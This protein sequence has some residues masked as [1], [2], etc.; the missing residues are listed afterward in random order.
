MDR[1]DELHV[2]KP[3]AED[4]DSLPSAEDTDSGAVPEDTDDSRS[5][6]ENGSL[7]QNISDNQSKSQNEDYRDR[8]SE[9]SSRRRRKQQKPQRCD[10][11]QPSGSNYKPEVVE[12]ND[13]IGPTSIDTN[14]FEGSQPET[15]INMQEGEDGIGLPSEMDTD[16][17]TGSKSETEINMQPTS[18]KCFNW[19]PQIVKT[20]F[21]SKLLHRSFYKKGTSSTKS[22]IRSHC[23]QCAE[24]GKRYYT[25]KFLMKHISIKHTIKVHQCSFCGKQYKL[26]DS[27]K[28]HIKRDHS[29]ETHHCI[30]CDKYF[31]S[32][33]TLKQH[34]RIHTGEKP[35]SC[36]HCRMRFRYRHQFRNHMQAHSGVFMNCQMCGKL[37]N[38]LDSYKKHIKMC[39]QKEG[40]RETNISNGKVCRED[41]VTKTEVSDLFP[42]PSNSAGEKESTSNTALNKLDHLHFSGH[43]CKRCDV[44]FTDRQAL[45]KHMQVKHRKVILV[46][47]ICNMQYHLR[48]SL[49]KHVKS[50]HKLKLKDN[51]NTKAELE[52]RKKLPLCDVEIADVELDDDDKEPNSAPAESQSDCNLDGAS[53]QPLEVLSAKQYNQMAKMYPQIAKMTKCPFCDNFYR[54]IETLRQHIKNDHYLNDM[55]NPESSLENKDTTCR[56]SESSTVPVGDMKQNPSCKRE[57]G[58]GDM[59]DKKSGFSSLDDEKT[60]YQQDNRENKTL[61]ED[62]TTQPMDIFPMMTS[63]DDGSKN[64]LDEMDHSN[65]QSQISPQKAQGECFSDGAPFKQ[66]SNEDNCDLKGKGRDSKDMLSGDTKVQ[67][68]SCDTCG[69][70]LNNPQDLDIHVQMHP[71][72]PLCQKRYGLKDSLRK[73]IKRSHPEY[74][75]KM[76]KKKSHLEKAQLL[77]TNDSPVIPGQLRDENMDEKVNNEPEVFKCETC[78]LCFTSQDELDSHVA[79]HPTCPCCS[80]RYT[81]KDSLRKHIKRTHPALHWEIAEERRNSKK[82]NPFWIGQDSA[83]VA[84]GVSQSCEAGTYQNNPSGNGQSSDIEIHNKTSV[85]TEISLSAH[86]S[87]NLPDSSLK[88]SASQSVCENQKNL[89]K[90]SEESYTCASC[91]SHFDNEEDLSKHLQMQNRPMCPYCSK[92]YCL[93]DSLRKHL[94]RIHGDQLEDTGRQKR[95]TVM[96]D[97][98]LPGSDPVCSACNQRFDN[99]QNLQEHELSH[100][101]C[102]YCGKLYALQSSLRKHIWRKHK[103]ETC[104]VYNDNMLVEPGNSEGSPGTDTASN[105][106]DIINNHD[107]FDDSN[108]YQSNTFSQQ[109]LPG[110]SGK[111]TSLSQSVVQHLSGSEGKSGDT[112]QNVFPCS[113][114]PLVFNNQKAIDM[115][116][117]THVACQYCGKLYTLKDSLRRHIKRSHPYACNMQS[118][119]LNVELIEPSNQDGSGADAHYGEDDGSKET[120]S[121]SSE[122]EKEKLNDN[123]EEVKNL[124]PVCFLVFD[125]DE[126]YEIHTSSHPT[127]QECGKMYRLKDSLKKHMQRTHPQAFE[128]MRER[129]RQEELMKKLGLNVSSDQSVLKVNKEFDESIDNSA[130]DQSK[131]VFSC[132]ACQ[133]VCDSEDLLDEHIQIHPACLYC[134]KSYK[135]IDS[136]RKHI[137]RS[138]PEEEEKRRSGIIFCQDKGED[139]K[140]DYMYPIVTGDSSEGASKCDF[141]GDDGGSQSVHGTAEGVQPVGVVFPCPAAA[142]TIMFNTKESL[143]VHASSH[144]SCRYC[145]KLYSIRNSLRKHIQ[146]SHPVEYE[147]EK[148]QSYDE[149]YGALNM[150]KAKDDEAHDDEQLVHDNVDPP[151]DVSVKNE[152]MQDDELT[153]G[154]QNPKIKVEYEEEKAQ[155][156]D[157][158]YGTSEAKDDDAHDEEQLMHDNEDP[159]GDISV[160]NEYMQDD[161]HGEL[162]KGIQN[163]KIKVELAV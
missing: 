88:Y 158:F 25:K 60:N 69:V 2:C 34:W 56:S 116:I 49:R 104:F 40:K 131:Q 53:S 3:M 35:Y 91:R 129:K 54:L 61:N 90:T 22:F 77:A 75:Q 89:P 87:S 152:Y 120:V 70:T 24:C 81:L 114:C 95:A 118:S 48:D 105:S 42:H 101:K 13:C 73:H 46:C 100:R 110:S 134:G 6:E 23:H 26:S 36:N 55:K 71:T 148:A 147:E 31:S 154:I 102:K 66:L 162:I 146:R 27:L 62:E 157:E 15:E 18:L 151:G 20:G 125:N 115:H 76:L 133:L 149:F 138:H 140:T 32:K 68:C 72:C 96:V 11:P 21:H 84:A 113:A 28:K 111:S 16:V 78:D 155:S 59:T 80:K 128:A 141:V 5:Q 97:N 103:S 117:Q 67:D 93:K 51:R 143:A 142:C 9:T 43:Y 153:K 106:K 86:Q 39:H 50:A 92:Q 82:N 45:L 64:N 130:G 119:D 10:R 160:K 121:I 4:M 145:G 137:K 47:P 52:I 57:V 63:T 58:E 156:Y 17:V 108:S 122:Q 74:Y 83:D 94:K 136:L 65:S 132:P 44:S 161:E 33:E 37:Y 139:S 1:H 12:G 135:L 19:K 123:N 8:M 85:T 38:R 109:E 99:W 124:C 127:C 14:G 112:T 79:I 30:R 7:L 29:G 144:Y 159:T 150:L 98:S 107:D 126:A 163:P 41:L